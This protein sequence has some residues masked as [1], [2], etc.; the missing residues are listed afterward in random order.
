M[1]KKTKNANR[2]LVLVATVVTLVFLVNISAHGQSWSVGVV[3]SGGDVGRHCSIDV[4]SDGFPHISYYDNTN[5]NLKYVKWTGTDWNITTVDSIGDVGDYSSIALDSNDR[6]HVSYYDATNDRL[7]YA[8]KDEIGSWNRSFHDSAGTGRYTSIALDSDDEPHMSYYDY[9][10]ADLKHAWKDGFVWDNETVDSSGCVGMWTSI[11]VHSN[12]DIH[13]SYFDDDTSDLKYAKH[14]GSSWSTG[15]I[16]STGNVGT[17][18]S[19]AVN[20]AGRPHIVYRDAS[21]QVIKYIYKDSYGSWQT[22]DPFNFA[23]SGWFTSIALDSINNPH[24]TCGRYVNT[25]MDLV[26]I[27]WEGYWDARS[28]E[29]TGAVDD[30]WCTSIALDGDDNPHICYYDFTNGDLKYATKSTAI[31][32]TD[33]DEFSDMSGQWGQSGPGL[34]G[35]LDGDND[36]DLDDLQVF[37]NLYWLIAPPPPPPSVFSEDFDDGDISDW[38]VTVT[39]DATFAP[40]TAHYVSTPYGLH[41]NST[42]DYMAKGVSPSYT[43]NLTEDYNVSFYFMLPHANNHWFEVFNNHQIY[44]LIDY[45][46]DLKSYSPTQPITTL[47]TG[48]W[49][50]IEIKAHQSLNSYDVYINDVQVATCPFWEHT[51]FETTFQIGDRAD[52]SADKGEAYWDDF[53]ITQ[54]P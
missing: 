52:G 36:V 6:P 23:D 22:E 30:G 50:Y 49:Y 54:Q 41:M 45:G 33:L 39:G 19:I 7:K 42:G 15:T 16:V 1:R 12:D 31:E 26:Y 25:K 3:D 29:F 13:I 44:L 24:M 53:V 4:D 27:S 11:A 14:D 40:S 37:V 9:T 46:T 17:H 32:L 2:V 5:G 8:Y 18:S 35:D 51:G 34:A 20:S 48:M 21:N 10:N 43:L 38:T 28:P 47:T